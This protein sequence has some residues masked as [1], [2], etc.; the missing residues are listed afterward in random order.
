MPATT[1]VSRSEASSVRQQTNGPSRG[2]ANSETSEPALPKSRMNTSGNTKSPVSGSRFAPTAVTA[3]RFSSASSVEARCTSASR[4]DREEGLTRTSLPDAGSRSGAA[5][6][7]FQIPGLPD[8]P[9][10]GTA[11][12][13]RGGARGRHGRPDGRHRQGLDRDRGRD[14]ARAVPRRDDGGAR[15]GRGGAAGA[16]DATGD[17]DARGPTRRRSGRGAAGWTG[18]VPAD[19]RPGRGARR[20]HARR[21]RRHGGAADLGGRGGPVVRRRASGGRVRTTAA[22]RSGLP[23]LCDHGRGAAVPG[24]AR[25][26]GAPTRRRA[27]PARGARRRCGGPRRGHLGRPARPVARDAGVDTPGTTGPYLPVLRDHR[28]RTTLGHVTLHDWI[29]ELCDALDIDVEVDEGLILDLARDV[30]H[31]VD[32]PAAPVSTFLLGYA[33]AMHGAGPDKLEELAG[34]A[35]ALADVWDGKDTEEEFEDVEID[36][37]ELVDAD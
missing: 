14:P 28:R 22:A 31:A 32:R 6:C 24:P 25:A 16:D 26:A 2:S 35:S 9:G 19:T 18:P 17:L 4:S 13:R 20:G 5:R 23:G 3:S 1:V 21:Q 36:D 10:D 37:T 34:R 11:A 29:D 12:A 27:A 33:A 8:W 7:G 15:G 30:A